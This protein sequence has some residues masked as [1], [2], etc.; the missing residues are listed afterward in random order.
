[1]LSISAAIAVEAGDT[2]D[3]ITDGITAVTSDSF[4]W[5]VQLT[6]NRKNTPAANWAS[7]SGFHGPVNTE[8]YAALPAQAAR[9]WQLAFCRKP[10]ADELQL[11]TDF[12]VRQL[13]HL[14]KHNTQLP[15]DTTAGRQALTNFCQV[16]MSSNE[17]LYI[18]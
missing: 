13:D 5:T 14:A 11:A 4:A 6:L 15:K 7:T 17:F 2:I 10:T 1:M 16:L 8:S 12:F 9:A 18:D 3:F